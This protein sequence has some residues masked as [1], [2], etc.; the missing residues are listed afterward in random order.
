MMRQFFKGF[1]NELE[2][3]AYIDGYSVY[4]TFWA[5][6]IPNSFTMMI[7]IFSLYLHGSGRIFYTRYSPPKE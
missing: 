5:I 3:S 6:I 2:E 1:P 4:R 7:T